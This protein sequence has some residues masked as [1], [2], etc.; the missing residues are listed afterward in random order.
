MPAYNAEAFINR[1]VKSLAASTY[2]C[3]IYIVDDGSKVPVTTILKNSPGVT[4]LR[5]QKNLGVALARNVG[6]RAILTERYDF[7][8]CLD[9]DDICY[10]DRIARQ[11]EFLDRHPDV[12]AV[13]T[14]G[15]H[16]D[17]DSGDTIC[18][19]RTPETPASAKKFMLANMA[20]INTSAMMRASALRAVGLYS[21]RYPAAEDYE[22]FRRI[23]AR[24]A[25]ANIPRVLVDICI[26]PQG[27]SLSRRRRQL[28]DRLRI[29]LRYFEPTA[30]AA[31]VGLARTAL[32]FLVPTSLHAKVKTSNKNLY[33]AALSANGK[34]V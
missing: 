19:H 24:F 11:V 27:V 14:W 28:V 17:E 29:Q 6:L 22:L 20:V 2:P 21:E 7:V 25:I 32:L 1:A 15:R 30:V 23:S 5:H 31:W 18:V 26:S 13:G 10:P 34:L 4:V 33:E 9:A 16:F 3:D 8:A 12:A